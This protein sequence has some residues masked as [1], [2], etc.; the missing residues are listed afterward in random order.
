MRE[1]VD[2]NVRRLREKI[3]ENPAKPEYVQYKD[4]AWVI[5]SRDRT[6]EKSG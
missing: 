6:M 5:T 4:G 3:E 2:V 1:L